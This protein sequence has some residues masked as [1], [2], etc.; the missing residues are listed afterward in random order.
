MHIPLFFRWTYGILQTEFHGHI[1]QV[2]IIH[3][4]AYGVFLDET[5]VRVQ[6]RD[7][8]DAVHEMGNRLMGGQRDD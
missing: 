7:M 3:I 1:I 6:E 8:F 5:V 4:G 2:E